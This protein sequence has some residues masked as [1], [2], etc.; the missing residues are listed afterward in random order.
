MVSGKQKAAHKAMVYGMGLGAAAHAAMEATVNYTN[1]CKQIDDMQQ[2][3]TE[4]D[5]WCKKIVHEQDNLHQKIKKF[6]D[7]LETVTSNLQK[8]I[9]KHR[10]MYS[11]KIQRQEI[12]SAMMCGIVSMTLLIKLLIRHNLI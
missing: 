5:D 6:T 3:V 9:V 11:S 7:E 8:T 2:H 1:T 4:V 10:N 12:I